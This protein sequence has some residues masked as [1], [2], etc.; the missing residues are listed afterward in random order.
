MRVTET[1]LKVCPNCREG[2][3]SAALVCRF[4]GNDFRGS[5]RRVPR[6]SWIIAGSGILAAAL[7]TWLFLRPTSTPLQQAA[8]RG[9][10]YGSV[11]EVMDALSTEG[12]G[13][14][15]LKV[16]SKAEQAPANAY[17]GIQESAS[18]ENPLWENSFFIM[19][20]EDSSAVAGAIALDREITSSYV[21]DAPYSGV[22]Y[23]ENVHVSVSSPIMAERVKQALGG[24]V[25]CLFRCS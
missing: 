25:E 10:R 13:C 18:C 14:R 23:T 7:G 3:R 24:R 15:N 8:E 5:D 11:Q 22:V 12:I 6:R 16:F 20:F 9:P 1:N 17:Q 21:A 19:I 4:C 2:V